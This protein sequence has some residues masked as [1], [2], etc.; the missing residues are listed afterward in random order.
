MQGRERERGLRLQPLR[1]Q[2]A[3]VGHGRRDLCQEGGLPDAG[4]PLD[5]DAAGRAEAGGVEER[6]QL[7]PLGLS[8]MQHVENVARIPAL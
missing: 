4:F 3:Y 2:H 7:R 5:D 6:G 1:A 8:P